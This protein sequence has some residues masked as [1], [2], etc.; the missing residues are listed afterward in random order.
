MATQR[1]TR[2]KNI[3]NNITDLQRRVAYVEKLPAKRTIANGGVTSGKLS[4]GSVSK[5]NVTFGVV[6]P[7]S[8]KA[9]LTAQEA[10][11][12]IFIDDNPSSPTQGQATYVDGNNNEILI[13]DNDAQS[14]AAAAQ[15]SA[16]IALTA[17]NGK[18]KVFHQPTAPTNSQLV[19]VTL[20]ADDIWFNT[21]TG[22]RPSK[23]LSQKT[24]TNKQV[25][26]GSPGET[27]RATLTTSANHGFAVGDIVYVFGVGSP[28]DGTFNIVEVPTQTTF[29][30]ELNTAVISSTGASGS[31]NGWRPY[32]YSSLAVTN[33]DASVITSGILRG[34]SIFLEGGQIIYTTQVIEKK[35]YLSSI[36]QIE[37]QNAHGLQVGDEIIV[38]GLGAPWDGEWGI[39]STTGYGPAGKIIQY[40]LSTNPNLYG[41]YPTQ[42]LVLT[43]EQGTL[44]IAQNPSDYAMTVSPSLDVAMYPIQDFDANDSLYSPGVQVSKDFPSGFVNVDTSEW[45]TVMG[46]YGSYTTTSPF[47]SNFGA[48]FGISTGVYQPPNDI[49]GNPVAEVPPTDLVGAG[50]NVYVNSTDSFN[51]SRAAVV[52]QIYG[53]IIKISTMTTTTNIAISGTNIDS[54]GSYGDH[55][56]VMNYGPGVLEGIGGIQKGTIA[57]T[58]ATVSAATLSGGKAG[59]LVF[60]FD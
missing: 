45:H 56:T 25:S 38:T 4:V 29:R 57:W 44:R 27:N 2:R 51:I 39:S 7:L 13:I 5:P 28:F 12:T 43:G 48:V 55:K 14:S 6:R 24:I 10:Q 47:L 58:D 22:N 8:D 50:L 16:G 31:V 1:R 49:N 3:V 17:A 33:L 23:F 11:D 36:A 60:K 19:G 52:A 9:G 20:T 54:T 32:G 37:T 42:D 26:A 18:N 30:Y 46:A 35:G 59:D 53:D 21:D 40:V 34:R 41:W 15:S